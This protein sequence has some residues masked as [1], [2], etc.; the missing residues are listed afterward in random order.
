MLRSAK[1]SYERIFL[2]HIQSR[3]AIRAPCDMLLEGRLL[4]GRKGATIKGG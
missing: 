1:Q 2:Q 3:A 4:L